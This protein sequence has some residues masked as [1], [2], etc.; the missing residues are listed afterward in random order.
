MPKVRCFLI[1]NILL[2]MKTYSFKTQT[3]FRNDFFVDTEKDKKL[4]QI[5]E[6]RGNKP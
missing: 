2:K 6:N 5:S 4:T 1:K 3:A